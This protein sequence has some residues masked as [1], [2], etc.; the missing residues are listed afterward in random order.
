MSPSALIDSLTWRRSKSARPQSA[1]AMRSPPGYSGHLP[2]VYAENVFG[3][4][5]AQGNHEAHGVAPTAWATPRDYTPRDFD[6]SSSWLGSESGG[7]AGSAGSVDFAAVS[8]GSGGSAYYQRPRRPR[9][10][11]RS[12]RS[13]VHPGYSPGASIPGYQGH[14]PGI[15]AGNLI[16]TCTPRA[17]KAN[18]VHHMDGPEPPKSARY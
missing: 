14:V 4:T 18:W 3:R 9:S 8:A 16:S 10:V 6:A 13:V 1:T 17:A 5:H 7:S 2:G 12:R 15:Y 11:M